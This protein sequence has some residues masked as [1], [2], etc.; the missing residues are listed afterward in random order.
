MLHCFFFQKNF[1]SRD[2]VVRMHIWVRHMV[3]HSVAWDGID[4]QR[5]N[6]NESKRF[7]SDLQ[8]NRL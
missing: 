7:V 6:A 8:I 4:T 1:L 3:E 5:M 2:S